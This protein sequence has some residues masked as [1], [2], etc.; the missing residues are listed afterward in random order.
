MA[1]KHILILVHGTFAKNAPW[2]QERSFFS[3]NIIN[4]L[5][6]ENLII[7]FNWSGKNSYQARVD[8]GEELAKLL[9]DVCIKYSS[10]QKIVI[11]HSHGGNVI[12]YAF[13]KNPNRGKDYKIITLATPFL[14][15]TIRKD[16]NTKYAAAVFKGI[17]YPMGLFFTCFMLIFL[18]SFGIALQYKFFKPLLLVGLI[19]FWACGYFWEYFI[20]GKMM[21]IS[22]AYRYYYL[23]AMDKR[24]KIDITIPTN[25]IEILAITFKLDEAKMLLSFSTKVTDKIN[26]VFNHINVVIRKLFK[27]SEIFLFFSFLLIIVG[28]LF[29]SF[30]G[31]KLDIL[32][33]ILVFFWTGYAAF[34]IYYSNVFSFTNFFNYIFS[35]NPLFYGWKSWNHFLY[36]KTVPKAFPSH[37]TRSAYVEFSINRQWSLKLIH[38]QIYQN[39]AVINVIA[40]WIKGKITAPVA[41]KLAAK[42]KI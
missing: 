27:Y 36:I 42:T 26:L 30:T 13:K 15:S 25:E 8:A 1:P 34:W 14:I 5:G 18:I 32:V 40:S 3:M 31:I 19:P 9:D 21:S 7:P 29:E 37:I 10:H 35:A 24:K 17:I 20:E 23:K 41:I 4:K 2:I 11:G 22:D 38:S 16:K 28:A 6:G 39:D 12:C 33:D